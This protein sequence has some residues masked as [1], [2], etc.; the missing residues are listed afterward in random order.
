MTSSSTLYMQTVETPAAAADNS[1]PP[2]TGYTGLIGV[3]PV[4]AAFAPAGSTVETVGVGKEFASIAQ[5]VAAAKD[6]WTILVDAGTYTNDFTTI[7]HDVT[8]IGVGGV[9]HMVATGPPAN[10][11]GIITIDASATIENFAFSGAAVPDADGGNGA[12]IRY[13][14]GDMVLRNDSFTDNQDG[15]LAF[16]VLGLPSNTITLDHDTFD[17]NGSGSGYTHNAYIGAVDKLTVT[18]SVFEQAVVGHELKS[19]ALISDITNNSFYDGPTGTAS[20]DID[21]PNGGQDVVENN[22]IEKGPDAENDAM[23]HF[24]G[25]GIP[26]AGSSLLVQGDA[27]VDDKGSAIGVLNQTA[28]SA[29]IKADTFD[30]MTA[31]AIADGPAT[32]TDDYDGAGNAFP[33][34]SLVGVLPGATEIYTDAA[35]HTLLLDGSNGFQAVEGGAGLLTVTAIIGHIVVIGGSGG[36]DYTEVARSGG[37]SVTTAAG[38]ADTVVLSGQDT[39]DSEGNDAITAGSRQHHRRRERHVHHRGRLRLKSVEH[40]RHDRHHVQRQH[41]VHQPGRGRERH[42]RRHQPVSADQLQRRLGGVRR[43]HRGAALRGDA[44]RRLVLDADLR[45]SDEHHD[46]RW[47]AGR[48]HVADRRRRERHERRRR[49]HPGGLRHGRR[50]R[51]RGRAGLRRRR[52]AERVRPRRQRRGEGLRRRRRRHAGRRHRQPH[53]LRRR[54]RRL[55]RHPS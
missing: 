51:Q 14:G 18:N 9:V 10:L 6:G 19:R 16:P 15:L 1:A 35:P 55:R 3:Q 48:R 42:R 39:L 8:M 20:Y 38:A 4:A 32:E 47:S 44:G 43:Q 45:R 40:R 30:H 50:D 12:G 7:S 49:R 53:V 54:A 34:G 23:I 52:K 11:K 28:I 31:G 37:N 36:L 33:N 17:M 29:V 22:T 41:R 21:L 2:T 25:E 13:E 24:G 26:Y 46:G 27:F 5:A